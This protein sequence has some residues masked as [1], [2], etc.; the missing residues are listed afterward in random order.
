M[1]TIINALGVTSALEYFPF[2]VNILIE[3]PGYPV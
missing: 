3:Q 1:T 2:S